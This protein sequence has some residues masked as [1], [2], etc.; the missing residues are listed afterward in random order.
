MKISTIDKLKLIFQIYSVVNM[1]PTLKLK[2][3]TLLIPI[4]T[5][6]YLEFSYFIKF[7]QKNNLKNLNILDISSPHM[8]AYFLSK[9][10]NVIKTN[11]DPSEEI[12][13]KQNKKLAFKK[14]DATKLSFS[15]NTFDITYSISVIEHIYKDYIAAIQ[16]MIRVTKKSGYVYL[17]FPISKSHVEEWDIESIYSNQKVLNNKTF[18][19]YRFNKNDVDLIIK[20]LKNVD[21]LSMDIYWEKN[22]YTYDKA[23]QKLKYNKNKYIRLI[24]NSVINI[25]YGFTLFKK[26]PY[27]NFN[28]A[29]NFGNT[30]LIL[31]KK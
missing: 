24:S 28:N 4:E 19:Q 23:M 15:D 10:N 30:H 12:F 21:V 3:L 13:I 11:I 16:E 8:M 27:S 26:I 31:I 6:R 2:I 1:L 5:T 20:K 7:L 25:F 14:E 18:F 29:K 9:T 22:N 17:T